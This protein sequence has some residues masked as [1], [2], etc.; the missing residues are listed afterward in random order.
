[1]QN[2]LFI[3]KRDYDYEGKWNQH[4]DREQ[5][6]YGMYDELAPYRFGLLDYHEMFP[7]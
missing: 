4:C 7:P 6:E 1:M 2:R 5:N 3:R